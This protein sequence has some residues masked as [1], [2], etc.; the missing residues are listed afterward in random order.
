[1]FD[2]TGKIILI[3]GA[4]SGIGAACAR[5]A[6]ELGAR[7][8]ASGRN[9]D[10]LQELISSLAGAGHVSIVAN[11]AEPSGRE[12]LVEAVD[13]CDG[14]VH[15]A[16]NL[17]VTPFRF[18]REKSLRE[19]REVNYEAPCLIV[20]ALLKGKRLR[21]D[22][23]IVFITSVAARSGAKGHALY[24]GSKG[25]LEAAARCLALEVA[26]QRIRVNCVAPGMVRTAMAGEAADAMGE[27][28]MRRH[29]E[30]YPLGFGSPED[31]AGA[32]GFLLANASRWITGTTLVVDGGFTMR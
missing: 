18:V 21:P 5:L 25:A 1:M 14:F 20:Q 2:L 3:T 26:N 30:E 28:A 10:R 32:V 4:S 29:E 16:G 15:A 7:V 12:R 8:V 11:L 6:A 13:G 23:S 22:G 24:S 27:E 17:V 31:V 19:A 9:S